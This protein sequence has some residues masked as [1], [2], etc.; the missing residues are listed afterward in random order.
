MEIER[1]KVPPVTR[2]NTAQGQKS[3]SVTTK[4]TPQKPLAIREKVVA[5]YTHL[6]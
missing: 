4:L 1:S 6:K 5:V 2:P 3:V